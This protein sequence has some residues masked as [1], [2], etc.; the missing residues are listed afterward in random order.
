MPENNFS[1]TKQITISAIVI[2]VY[3]AV[4]LLSQSFAFGQYQIR[5]ATSI[6]ALAAIYPFLILPMGLANFLSNTLMGGLGLPDMIGGFFAGILTAGG[7]FYMKKISI[8]L[9]A[10]PILAIPTLLVPIWL[11]YL[12]QIP[13]QVLVISIGLGQIL[14]AITGVFIVKYLEKPLTRL[15]DSN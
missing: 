9:I 6:Y 1:K 10:L 14:P 15:M 3:I 2:A 5:I 4:M 13:Y 8:Y 11:S 7:C 12:L